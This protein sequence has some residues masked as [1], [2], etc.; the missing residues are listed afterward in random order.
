[1]KKEKKMKNVLMLSV[2]SVL[3]TNAFATVDL[4]SIDED[5]E[6]LLQENDSNIIG[7]VYENH[8]CIR[9]LSVVKPLIEAE[10]T[11]D[12][13]SKYNIEINEYN[14]NIKNFRFEAEKYIECI[15]LYAEKGQSDINVIKKKV[16]SSIDEANSFIKIYQK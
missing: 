13:I 8:N 1:M 6:I 16:E 11:N 3:S 4:L 9:P 2:I 10:K 15:S 14:K 7:K 12:M 5:M